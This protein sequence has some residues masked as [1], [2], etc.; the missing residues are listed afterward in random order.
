MNSN[1]NNL[2]YAERFSIL[3]GEFASNL[4]FIGLSGIIITIFVL[5][6]LFKN[7]LK[8]RI[9]NENLKNPDDMVSDWILFNI[10]ILVIMIVVIGSFILSSFSFS[11]SLLSLSGSLILYIL[12]LYKEKEDKK[13][14]I[15]DTYILFLIFA[16]L[17]VGSI[18]GEF[19]IKPVGFIQSIV[20][21]EF[22]SEK[23]A[24]FGFIQMLLSCSFLST[25]LEISL[26][27][28]SW[29][30]PTQFSIYFNLINTTKI[31]NTRGDIIFIQSLCVTVVISLSKSN[32]LPRY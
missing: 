3:F 28:I 23:A 1:L 27:F 2:I 17:V 11:H 9:K 5:Y 12:Y 20:H 21:S 8:C 19:L 22:L 24:V 25:S 26:I 32:N 14:K 31:E 18:T 4:F 29:S 6:A 16:F 15:K 13:L 7:E 10:E 30:I